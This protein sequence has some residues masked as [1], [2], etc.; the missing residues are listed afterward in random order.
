MKE[1]LELF[2][3]T[4]IFIFV[5]A[6]IVTKI[7]TIQRVIFHKATLKHNIIFVII[8]GAFSI[9]GTLVGIQIPSGAISNIRDFAPLLAGLIAG[10]YIGLAVGLIGGIHRFFM[11]GISCVPCSISTVLAGIIGGLVFLWNKKRLISII[12]GMLLAIGVEALHGAITLL[13]VRPFDTALEIVETAIPSMMIANA[14]GLAI[15][16]IIT[17]HAHE[18]AK[19]PEQAVANIKPPDG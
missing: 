10:P 1:L 9:F 17:G 8:F 16:I 12:Q 6:E 14:I 15:G 11:G 18:D 3:E 19:K 7:P 5:F 13:M 4:E 2:A